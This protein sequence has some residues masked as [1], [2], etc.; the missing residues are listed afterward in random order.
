[1]SLGGRIELRLGELGMTQAELSRR[2]RVPQTTLN[3]L[4]KRG[5]RT[6]PHLLAIARELRTTAAFLTGETDD[7]NADFPEENLTAEERDW[8]DCLRAATPADRK[9]LAQLARSLA[10][11]VP[12][13]SVHGNQQAYRA[14]G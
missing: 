5:S 8:I 12:S 7:P 9:A 3:S 1:M 10:H 2:A 14:E 6:S 4:I 11:N 13:S